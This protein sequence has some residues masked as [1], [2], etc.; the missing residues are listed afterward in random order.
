MIIFPHLLIGAA[1]GLKFHNPW[2]I[3]I[4]ALASHFIADR[5]PHWEYLSKKL[6]DLN[7]KELFVFLLKV[8]IDS[9]LGL[10]LLFCLLKE[11]NSWPYA[12]FGAFI[13]ALPD[14]PLLLVRFFPR[15]KWLIYYQKF[16]EANHLKQK[17]TKKNILPMISELTVAALAILAIGLK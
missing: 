9:L 4:L 11:Q 14:F 6:K 10:L 16:H 2:A 12:I 5:I 8:A 1:I 17:N 7:K 13:S 3:F 15:V